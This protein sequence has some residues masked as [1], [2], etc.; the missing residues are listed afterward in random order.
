MKT[1]KIKVEITIKQKITDY[2]KRKLKPINEY[3]NKN[4]P[5]T[6]AKAR[7]MNHQKEVYLDILTRFGINEKNNE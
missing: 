6:N 7:K 2:I 4:S 3:L 1:P 5:H